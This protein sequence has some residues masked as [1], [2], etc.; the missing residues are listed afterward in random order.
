[1]F[2]LFRSRPNK[3]A[4]VI[5]T[6]NKPWRIMTWSNTFPVGVSLSLESHLFVLQTLCVVWLRAG[7]PGDRGS[8][9][10]RGERIFF[11]SLCVQ[12][13]SGAHPAS[14]TMGTGDPF[15]VVKRGRGVTLTS[16]PHLVPRSR[17]SRSYTFSPPSTCV[18]CRGTAFRHC[19]LLTCTT[20]D[21]NSYSHAV[22]QSLVSDTPTL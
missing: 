22:R 11:C 17:I 20:L 14:C 7:R 8:I 1:M 6:V 4:M 16:H 5:K 18:A 15:L 19:V 9:P 12:T 13:G 2:H 10:G 3:E 21:S